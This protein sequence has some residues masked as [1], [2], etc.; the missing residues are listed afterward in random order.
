VILAAAEAVFA[1][2]GY[3]RARLEDVAQAVGIRRASLLYHFHDKPTLYA[4]V[5][6]GMLDDLLSRHRRVLDGDGPAGVRLEETIDT[7][8]DFTAE[9]PALI[10]IMLRELANGVSEHSRPFADRALP[11]VTALVDVISAGQSEGALRRTTALHVLMIL[12]GAS[13]FMTLG[14]AI[15]ARNPTERFPVMVDREQHR[16]LLIAIMRKLLGTGGP[17]PVIDP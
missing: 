3:D 4:A 1:E 10:R 15:Y 12:A 11:I 2:H 9:R 13:T 5:L 6:D 16:E 8:L 7:W 14:G 17:R